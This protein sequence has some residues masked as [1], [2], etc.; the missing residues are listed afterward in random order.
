[1]QSLFAVLKEIGEGEGG[2]GGGGGGGGEVIDPW[3]PA[4]KFEGP[5]LQQQ[6]ILSASVGLIAFLVFSLVRRRSPALFAPRTK[7]NGFTP[8]AE[9]VDDGI[10]SW[11]APTL[12][13]EDVKIL[14]IVGLDA[15]IILSFFKMAFWI[16]FFLTLWS[17]AVVMPVNYSNHGSIDGVAPSEEPR[18]PLEGVERGTGGNGEV[19]LSN[20]K[21]GLPTSPEI[22]WSWSFPTSSPYHL[23]HLATVYIF[24]AII[25]RALWKGSHKFIRSRQLYALE[26]LQSI[27]AR[28]IEVRNLPRHLQKERD[29]AEYFEAFGLKVES[30]AV[31]RQTTGL[32]KMLGK[33][34]EALYRLERTWCRWLGNPTSA[35][36]YEPEAIMRAME[37]KQDYNIATVLH[38]S[39]TANLTAAAAAASADIE[40]A[41]PLLRAT[42]RQPDEG[43]GTSEQDSSASLIRAPGDR[44]RPSMRLHPWNPF[45]SRVDAIHLLET[46]FTLLDRDV[47]R[48]RSKA[49]T[50]TSVGFVTFVDSMSA[51]S[52]AKYDEAGHFI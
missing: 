27:P 43:E 52:E 9:G 38:S 39:T 47:K 34:A 13:T 51:V 21:L 22:P 26:L 30:T 20:F 24:T 49:A 50:P 18:R 8:H 44:L 4:R 28:T 40:A 23:T 45:S 36:N 16:F 48:L 42:E 12:R 46:R 31:V 7:L 10:F 2:G 5:W 11:I 17:C 25:L 19:I 14:H 29:L 15:A 41:E 1:M 32:K 33:R 37:K 6:L 3:P 35:T